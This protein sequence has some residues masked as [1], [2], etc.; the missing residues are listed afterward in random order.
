MSHAV[1]DGQ[2]FIEFLVAW[3]RLHSLPGVRVVVH[4]DQPAVI[5]ILEQTHRTPRPRVYINR[6]ACYLVF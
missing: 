6:Y 3:V 4:M 5:N 2:G 1:S